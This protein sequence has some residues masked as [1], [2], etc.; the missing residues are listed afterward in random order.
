MKR[1]FKTLKY[2]RVILHDMDVWFIHFRE[3]GVKKWCHALIEDIEGDT[4][5]IR[6]DIRSNSI[7]IQKED[8]IAV[9]QS[10][11]FSDADVRALCRGDI[12][13]EDDMKN[14]KSN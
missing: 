12:L 7:V 4:I 14:R 9:A 5:K 6:T 3:K 10:V 1:K 13:S 8:I 2:C 11:P